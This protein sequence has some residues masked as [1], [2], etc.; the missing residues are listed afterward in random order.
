MKLE[1]IDINILANDFIEQNEDIIDYKFD[2]YRRYIDKN[3]DSYGLQSQISFE[4]T[5][6]AGNFNKIIFP[7]P[8]KIRIEDFAFMII[9]WRYSI[10]SLRRKYD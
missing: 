1:E 5:P 10:N 2:P 9:Y 8:E 3:G 4:F 7:C 6:P